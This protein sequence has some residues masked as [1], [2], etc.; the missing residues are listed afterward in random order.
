MITYCLLMSREWYQPDNEAGGTTRVI[1]TPY[2]SYITADQHLSIRFHF[3]R[4][5]F[6]RWQY[7]TRI[8][9]TTTQRRVD[10][11]Y[12]QTCFRTSEVIL[13]IDRRIPIRLCPLTSVRPVVCPR[14]SGDKRMISKLF[15]L[16][17]SSLIELATATS[18]RR[19]T[20][21]SCSNSAS[22]DTQTNHTVSF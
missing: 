5:A 6:E 19:S 4:F 14:A 13:Y 10:L 1:S 2:S 8:G 9:T 11:R 3:W 21:F 16:S 15:C 22:V 17:S 20:K 7:K 18:G 12:A